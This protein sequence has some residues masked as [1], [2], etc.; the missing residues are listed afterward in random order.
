MFKQT[1]MALRKNKT[2]QVGYLEVDRA[3]PETLV[4]S[5]AVSSKK[6]PTKYC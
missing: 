3:V 4:G 6:V 5:N 2:K 1:G